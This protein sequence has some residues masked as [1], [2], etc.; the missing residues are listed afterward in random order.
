MFELQ[1]VDPVPGLEPLGARVQLR[2]LSYGAMRAAMTS[3]P[4]GA[5]AGEALLGASL[6]VDGAPL[7]LAALDALPGRF[8]GAITRALAH[9]LALHGLGPPTPGDA[10]NDEA[11]AEAGAPA[12]GEA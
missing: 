8:A 5:R 12:A 1:T 6:M 11:P 3:A 7:G 9:C 2:E 10:A 4:D